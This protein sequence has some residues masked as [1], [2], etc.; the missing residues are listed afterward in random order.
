SRLRH[1]V[2]PVPDQAA[3]GEDERPLARGEL[4]QQP[5]DERLGMTEAIHARGI[6]PVDAQLD[7][8][9][10]CRQRLAFILWSPAIGPAAAANGPG[11]ESNPRDVHSAPAERSSEE[12]HI[13]SLRLNL[14][15]IEGGAKS[16]E[17][18]AA[19]RSRERDAHKGV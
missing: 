8:V 7:R 4:A 12:F 15:A 6:D 2:A 16:A 17:S 10:H 5:S 9:P 18:T 11:S 14:R 19:P 13:G 1:R 3:L